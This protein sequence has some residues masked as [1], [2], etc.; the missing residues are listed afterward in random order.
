LP[1]RKEPG[2]I[3]ETLPYTHEELGVCLNLNRVTV[4]RVLKEFRESGYIELGQKKIKVINRRGL[5][6]VIGSGP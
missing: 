2:V 4:T 5:E 6:T 1:S 3:D